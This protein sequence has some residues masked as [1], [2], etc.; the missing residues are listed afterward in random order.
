MLS[1]LILGVAVYFGLEL[2]RTYKTYDYKSFFKKLFEPYDKIFVNLWDAFYIYAAV[3]AIAVAIAG[4][5]GLICQLFRIPYGIAVI[6]IGLVLLIFTIFGSGLVRN[7]S[8]FMSIFIIIALFIVSILGIK[9]GL[10]NL[11]RVVCEQTTSAGFGKIF[12]MAFLY[13]SFQSV[14]IA[15]IISVSERLQTRNDAFQAALYGFLVNGTML[16]LVCITLLGFFPAVVKEDLPVYFVANRLGH[17]WL[18]IL[19]SSV[20]FFALISTGV[21]MMY[22]VVKR[23]EVTWNQGSGIFKKVV[24]RR[25]AICLTFLLLSAGIS[26]FGLT[27]IVAKGY[28]SLGIIAIVLNIIPLLLIA[29]IK[30]SRANR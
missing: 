5:S 17:S 24:T 18:F 30:I 6:S 22:G 27:A 28:G 29:P 11:G 23:F 13:G 10:N 21:G 19:Y 4:S 7:A 15:P 16:L 25:M 14:L 20:L 12:W 8:T 1:M 26:L 3:L 9:S 2:S